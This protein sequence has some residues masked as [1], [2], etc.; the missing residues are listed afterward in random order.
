MS[1]CIVYAKNASTGDNLH[2]AINNAAAATE[3]HHHFELT[4]WREGR[5]SAVVLRDES[6]PTTVQGSPVGPGRGAKNDMRIHRMFDHRLSVNKT[7]IFKNISLC[8]IPR[9]C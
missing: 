5:P 7:S 3:I 6:K 4:D 2:T 9:F 1:S 8:L